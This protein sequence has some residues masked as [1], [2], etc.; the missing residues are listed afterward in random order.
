MK[1]YMPFTY[2]TMIPYLLLVLFTD[3]VIGYISY[4]MLVGTRTDMAETNIRTGMKQASSNIRYQMDEIQRMSD[5]LFGSLSFQRALQKKG[6][7]YD[8][9][10]VMLDE[11]VPQITSPLKLFGNHI[12]LMLYTFNEDLNIVSGDNLDEQIKRSDYYILS[13]H[14]IENT[15]WYKNNKESE[16]DNIWL[17]IDT[18]RKLGNI[19][20]IRRLVSYSDYKTVIGYVRIT[21]SLSDLFGNFATFPVDQGVTVRLRKSDTNEIIFQRG[22]G[23][24]KQVNDRFLTLQETIKD[25]GFYIEAVVPPSYLHKDAGKM[26]RIIFAVCAISFLV[27]ACIGLLVARLSGRKMS[28]IVTLVRTFQE[29]NFQKRIRFSGNDE[30][31][32]IA[33]A[34]NIMAKNIQDLISSVYVQDIKRKQAELEALQSQI[35][36]HFLYNTLSTISSLANLGETR[37]VTEMVQGLSRFYR[38]TLNQGH[39]EIE[40]EQELQQVETY[41]EIQKVKYAD[42][43]AV[44]I[45][46]EPEIM[47]AVVIK[48]ILQPFVENVFKHAWFDESIAIRIS[49]RRVGDEIELKVIDNGIGMREDTVE[50][51]LAGKSE[52][53][54]YGV[55]NVDER[56]KLKYGQG[57]GVTI[58]SIYGA[59][60]TV[61]IRLPYESAEDAARRDDETAYL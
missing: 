61:R 7:P 32:Q 21:A 4:A 50:R 33:D 53:G 11:I 10:L 6:T 39:V 36:P 18:D 14:D 9:Y 45:D 15:T 38:L 35:N 34:F 40:M 55:K 48:V 13:Y 54:G 29:G 26:Q 41:L 60:T 37:K 28:R 23:D 25:S 22:D 46:V 57:Y 42:A 16:H 12:R 3:A 2:K 51:I 44:Y 24:D 56:I 1:R 20:H 31:R 59:G 27:M 8:I 5:T 17:Q 19:S 58:A 30:F 43:F 52:T 47:K 49:G